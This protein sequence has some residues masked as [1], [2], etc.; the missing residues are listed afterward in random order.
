MPFGFKT[1]MRQDIEKGEK[2]EIDFINGA[3][4][5][6]GEKWGVPTPVNRTLVAAIKG[7]EFGLGKESC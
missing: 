6:L 3:V 2:N 5:R 4:V 1:S 7:I